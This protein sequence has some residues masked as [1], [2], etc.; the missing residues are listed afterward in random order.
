MKQFSSIYK[1]KITLPIEIGSTILYGKFLNKRGIVKGFSKDKNNQPL[2]QLE[3]GKEIPLLKLRI[4]SLLP[5]KENYKR[6]FKEENTSQ[7][8]CLL[9]NLNNDYI[10]RNIKL[11]QRKI[12]PEDIYNDELGNFGLESTPHITL[13]YGLKN[14]SDYEEL[15]NYFKTKPQI[16][17]TIG[18]IS[19]FEVDSKPYDVLKFEVN[20][21]DLVK[22]NSYI[23][24]NFDC[25]ITFPDYK[26]HITITYVK[27]GTGKN[28]LRFESDLT[29]EVFR[30]EDLIYSLA[31]DRK[32]KIDLER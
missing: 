29:D 20:S 22:Y 4:A 18:E 17:F 24:N 28:Y 15:Q 10:L 16:K 1:E 8:H 26:P 11:L 5:V 13:L 25:E 30:E 3:G 23:R 27:K 31:D 2:V 21:S 32:L 12:K 14:E 19:L 9:L 7:F 6:L